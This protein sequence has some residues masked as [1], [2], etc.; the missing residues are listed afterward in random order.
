MMSD[1]ETTLT[2]ETAPTDEVTP[3]DEITPAD[4]TA[5]AEA[6]V[7]DDPGS[8][9]VL[10]E[11]DVLVEAQPAPVSPSGDRPRA[12]AVTAAEQASYGVTLSARF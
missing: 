3:A 12:F 5:P 10:D 6:V 8:V 7:A 1:D 11:D 2:D 4:E 9:A